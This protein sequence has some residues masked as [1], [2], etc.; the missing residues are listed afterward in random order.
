MSFLLYMILV[1]LLGGEAQS[2]YAGFSI[3]PSPTRIVPATRPLR[4]RVSHPSSSDRKTQFNWLFS[5]PP[6]SSAHASGAWR[7]SHPPRVRVNSCAHVCTWLTHVLSREILSLTKPNG[8]IYKTKSL[9]H[10]ITWRRRLLN[11]CPKSLM[12]WPETVYFWCSLV[13]IALPW[14]M[15][16]WDVLCNQN[17][18]QSLAWSL[19]LSLS[20]YIYIYKCV[21]VCVCVHVCVRAKRWKYLVRSRFFSDRDISAWFYLID[22]NGTSTR[23]VLFYA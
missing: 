11:N 18:S 8:K 20:L 22:F 23:F 13:N 5:N 16:L 9:G 1:L 17:I 21:C 19:L 12:L 4:A 15:R 3:C 6:K 14:I 2:F 10:Y 7:H